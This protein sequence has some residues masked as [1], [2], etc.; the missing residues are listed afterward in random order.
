VAVPA[1]DLFPVGES[2]YSPGAGGTTS[3]SRVDPKVALQ[4]QWTPDVMTYVQYSTGYKSEYQSQTR[5]GERHPAVPSDYKDLQLSEFL[6]PPELDVSRSSKVSRVSIW[7]GP[8]RR[9]GHWVSNHLPPRRSQH[10][11]RDP[12]RPLPAMEQ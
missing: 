10:S 6:P 1:N 5:S 3:L 4:Y 7:P 2:V 9:L 11:L 8:G 12:I